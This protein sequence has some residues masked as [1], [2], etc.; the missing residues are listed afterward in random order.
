MMEKKR[1]DDVS[2]IVLPTLNEKYHGILGMPFLQSTNPSID[3][4]NKRIS[5]PKVINSEIVPQK[6]LSNWSPTPARGRLL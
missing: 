4:K 3:W 5:W 6:S 2:F 1:I